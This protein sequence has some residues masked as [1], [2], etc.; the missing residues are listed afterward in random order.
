MRW[1]SNDLEYNQLKGVWSTVAIINGDSILGRFFF[2]DQVSPDPT[3]TRV[4]IEGGA[5]RY[6]SLGQ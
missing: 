4:D 5:P 6:L 2:D 1:K 3:S